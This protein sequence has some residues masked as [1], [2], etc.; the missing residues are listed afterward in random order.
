M[1][2]Q[3]KI[4]ELELTTIIIATFAFLAAG[5]V[6][7]IAGGGGL[8]TVPSLLLLNIPPHFALGTNK[9][10][11][12]IGTLTA[13]WTFFRNKL[14]V[15]HLV[16]YGF[17]SAFVGGVFGSW[18]ALQVDSDMLGKS[19]AFLL[20]LA[21]VFS[22]FSGRTL[23]KDEDIPMQKQKIIVT[24]IGLIIGT[25]DGFFGPNTGSFFILALH[26]FLGLGL[27]HASG[28]TK[29]FNLA[30]NVGALVAFASGGVVIYALAIPC[31]IG[32]IVGNQLGARL[33]IKVGVGMVRYCLYVALSLLFGTLIYKY[34]IA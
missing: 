34:F 21:L 9:F 15:L 19:M 24:I 22:L 11:C 30:S 8:I 13:V 7:A 29:V 20:P 14:I 18:I 27:V 28:T 12:S 17:I 5:F 4:L 32:S 6:D 3:E 16:P 1:C 25:Y 10:A 2:V 26:M 23:S 31:A 33:A